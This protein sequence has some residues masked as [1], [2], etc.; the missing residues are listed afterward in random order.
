MNHVALM[1]HRWNVRA[2]KHLHASSIR[3]R[4]EDMYE[5]FL[6]VSRSKDSFMLVQN[7]NQALTLSRRT[8]VKSLAIMPIAALLAACGSKAPSAPLPS[9]SLESFPTELGRGFPLG[10]LV[11]ADNSET[12]IQPGDTAPNFRIQLSDEQGLYLS[13]LKGSPILINFWATWCGPC[14]LEMPEIVHHAENSSDLL[15]IAINVQETEDVVAAF[16]DDFSM[17]MPVVRDVDAEIRDLYQV[18]GMPTSVFIDKEG[19]VSTYREGVMSPNML[20][21]LLSPIL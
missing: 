7:T 13:D 3:V 21:D 19:K 14:R 11:G 5:E 17:N 18:R 2:L 9:V 15:V 12:G 6:F 20:E 8:L 4:S 1:A 16:A 10:T